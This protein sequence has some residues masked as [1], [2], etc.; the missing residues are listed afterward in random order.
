M[1]KKGTRAIPKGRAGAA[2]SF[3][4]ARAGIDGRRSRDL[5]FVVIKGEQRDASRISDHHR[6]RALAANAAAQNLVI[7]D[8]ALRKDLSAIIRT[9][10]ATISRAR[11]K[12][13][14]GRIQSRSPAMTSTPSRL[15]TPARTLRLRNIRS[16]TSGSMAARP[17]GRFSQLFACT[18]A[19][20]ASCA[21]A[22]LDGFIAGG[23]IA[24]NQWREVTVPL[25]AAAALARRLDGRIDLQNQTTPGAQPTLYIDDVSLVGA[26][27][28]SDAL[29]ADGFDTP[30]A[31]NLL[32]DEHDV[33]A[34]GMTSDRFTWRDASGSPRVA[35][36]AH[37]DG[38]AGPGGTQRR[39]A[40]RIPLRNRR[41]NAHRARVVERCV[42][43]RL[44]R[45]AP[46]Q[47]GFLHAGSRRHVSPR[48]SPARHVD[49]HL[50]RP[51][52]RDLPFPDDVSAL[53]H[54]RCAGRGVRR[55]GHDRL[56]VC[57]RSRP[58]AVGGDL[59]SLLRA[60]PTRSKTTRA[61]RTASC[62]STAARAKTRIASSPAS[63]GAIATGSPRR[64]TRPPTTARGR[65][66][67]RTRFR[68]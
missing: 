51:P 55:A 66:T 37:N 16:S 54:D 25:D 8:E 11:P 18:D 38:G 10:A 48:P 61:R 4:D 58:S 33:Q 57:D 53:L 26:G 43:F 42:R 19:S 7:Y 15:R 39:R 30:Q 68:T 64:R 13:T 14:E 9:A 12:P 35:V 20:A 46:D 17:A 21:D 24:A 36:L 3:C 63:A 27:G 6:L 47:R 41:R 50:R 5:G 23:A 65:G 52:S 62:S 44:R 32:V 59:G 40:A 45:L 60:A 67:C 29:F 22:P 56:D 31:A 1:L 28:G 49:A 34:G 2:T